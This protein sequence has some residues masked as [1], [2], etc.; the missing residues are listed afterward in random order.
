MIGI[1][2]KAAIIF[3]DHCQT[4]NFENRFE[5]H[6]QLCRL[7]QSSVFVKEKNFQYK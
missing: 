4:E 7:P 2:D 6:S 1:S 3:A 5:N